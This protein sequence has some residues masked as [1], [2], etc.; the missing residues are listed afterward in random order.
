MFSRWQRNNIKSKRLS[1]Y[2][3]LVRT[4]CYSLPNEFPLDRF[5]KTFNKKENRKILNIFYEKIVGF[6]DKTSHDRR[7]PH[8]QN[9]LCGST[10]S[11][12]IISQSP[13]IIITSPLPPGAN[14]KPTFRIQRNLMLP[15]VIIAFDTSFPTSLGNAGPVCDHM[16]FFS[17]S[18]L[19]PKLSLS[20][21]LDWNWNCTSELNYSLNSPRH[22]YSR[23][24]RWPIVISRHRPARY[25]RVLP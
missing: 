6:S 24:L 7:P 18:E 15:V 16:Y 5:S 13:D 8:R 21:C 22:T 9:R 20:F 4:N 14:T 23:S 19:Q 1:F 17:L 3:R 10:S 11:W 12:E 2:P 25:N